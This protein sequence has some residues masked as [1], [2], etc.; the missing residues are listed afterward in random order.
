MIEAR[1]GYDPKG[2]LITFA[3]AFAFFDTAKVWNNTPGRDWSE[4]LTSA[5]V[6]SRITFDRKTTLRI[7]FAKP[8][9]RAPYNQPDKGWR[10]F[11]SLSKQF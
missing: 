2:D 10:T 4:Q 6:G 3:Q 5:G 8:L 11:V 7:E 9:S 1:I